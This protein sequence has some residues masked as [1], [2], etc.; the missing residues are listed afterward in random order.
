MI[1]SLLKE[2]RALC[3]YAA[4]HNL[5]AKLSANEWGF[6][7]KTVTVLAL[8][9]VKQENQLSDLH[10]SRRNPSCDRFNTPARRGE[11]Y[12]HVTVTG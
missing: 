10:W 1:K 12:C 5:P 9:G 8:V 2:K 4:D 11:Q 7:E 3:A 6:L